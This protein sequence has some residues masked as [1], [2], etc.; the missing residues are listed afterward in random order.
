MVSGLRDKILTSLRDLEVD[1]GEVL[2]TDTHEVN[3]IVMTSR[4]YHPLGEA[5]SYERL[6]SYV[7]SVVTDALNN[8]KHA[9]AAWRAGTVPD[10]NVIGEKQIEEMPF[11]A[12]K[13]LSRA[14]RIAVPLFGAAGLALLALL[15][16][17]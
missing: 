8:M 11:L 1:S 2:T 9:S 14:K 10:V 17:L 3:A 12:D 4:G 7:R 16:A 5:I 6:I 15:V 13:S